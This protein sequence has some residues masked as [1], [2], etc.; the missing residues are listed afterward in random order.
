MMEYRIET[1][2][3]KRFIHIPD[4][5]RLGLKNCFTTIDMDV[6]S[7]TNKS[8]E[9]IKAN[10]DQVYEFMG[11]RDLTL[12]N[13][14]Q[15]HTNKIEMIGS[16]DQGKAGPF[17]R[18]IP[19]TDGL[20]TNMENVVLLTR[21]ADCVP[22]L[23]YDPVNKVQANIHSGWK[24]TLGRIGEKGVQALV[25]EYGS[26]ADNILAV[27]GP[28]IGKND[29]EVRADVSSMFQGEFGMWDDL[30]R[31]KESGKWLIDLQEINKRLLMNLGIQEKHITVIDIS[32]FER[33]DLCHSYR[34]DGLSYGLMGLFTSLCK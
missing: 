27:V 12:Y 31:E 34:R 32:T 4:L 6:G 15:A 5:E 21:F 18:F 10:I 17:G 29:F 20:V 30:I 1:V 22:I 8:Q 19:N 25:G 2:N 26:D 13:G 28:A 3:Q 14:Y 23:L 7:S 11:L 9:S 16:L 24:G 33:K